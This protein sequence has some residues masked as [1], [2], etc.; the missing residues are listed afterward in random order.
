MFSEPAGG[1][2]DPP[3]AKPADGDGGFSKLARKEMPEP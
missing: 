2:E 1:E 3:G